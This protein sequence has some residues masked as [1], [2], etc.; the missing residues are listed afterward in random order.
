MPNPTLSDALAEY[1]ASAD[2]GEVE[3]VTLEIRHPAFTAPIRVVHNTVD[4]EARLEPLAPLN[5]GEVVTFQAYA[6]ELQLPEVTEDGNPF[7][8]IQID[9][10]SREITD[11]LD[12]AMQSPERIYVSLRVYLASALLDGPQ[13]DPVWHLLMFDVEANVFRVTARCRFFDPV[14]RQFPSKLYTAERFPGLVA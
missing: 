13:Q 3:L 8:T 11:N 9:N 6:F 5:P 2:P 7:L 12:R 1:Y 4:V 14:N 10:V